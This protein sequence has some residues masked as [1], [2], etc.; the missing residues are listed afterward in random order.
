MVAKTL[1]G[2]SATW[3]LFLLT[4][5]LMVFKRSTDTY[6]CIYSIRCS[7]YIFISCSLMCCR[8]DFC[9]NRLCSCNCLWSLYFSSLMPSSSWSIIF[10]ADGTSAAD[11]ARARGLTFSFLSVCSSLLMSSSPWSSTT[12]MSSLDF[13][14]FLLLGCYST[15]MELSRNTSSSVFDS[16]LLTRFSC[17]LESAAFV[18]YV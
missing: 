5:L 2:P 13:F 6:D 11:C 18:P 7:S 4:R 10:F 1:T 16:F 8:Y 17:E 9:F 14:C 12:R 15:A 3:V